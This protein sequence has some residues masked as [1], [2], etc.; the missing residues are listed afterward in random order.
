MIN[1]WRKSGKGFES[2]MKMFWYPFK[3]GLTRCG[4]NWPETKQKAGP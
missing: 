1:Q 2:L 4:E 3:N